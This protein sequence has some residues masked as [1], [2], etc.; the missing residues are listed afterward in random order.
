MA[1]REDFDSQHAHE[2]A[3][4]FAISKTYECKL[5]ILAVTVLLNIVLS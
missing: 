4:L 5:E 2:I 1:E 3:Y